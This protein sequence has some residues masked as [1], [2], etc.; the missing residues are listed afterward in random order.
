MRTAPFKKKLEALTT[1]LF[2]PED[3][4]PYYTPKQWRERGE[5]IGRDAVLTMVIEE[6]G[7]FMVLNGYVSGPQVTNALKALQEIEDEFG[8]YHEQ[9]YGWS[10]HWYPM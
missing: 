6:S 9:G 8:L 5:T 3:V 7:W 4:H 10:V 1:T 2:G